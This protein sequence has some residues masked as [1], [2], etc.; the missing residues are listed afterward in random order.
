[1]ELQSL[2]SNQHIIHAANQ[3]AD[4]TTLAMYRLGKAKKTIQAQLFDI[5][6]FA[7]FLEAQGIALA[8]SED[9]KPALFTDLAAWRFLDYGLVVAF[10]ASMLIDGFAIGSINR[11]LST[12]RLYATLAKLPSEQLTHI[13]A[14]HG[15][16]RKDGIHADEQRQAQQ[17]ATRRTPQKPT[18]TCVAHETLAGFLRLPATPSYQQARDTLLLCLMLEM[19][20]R[21]SEVHSLTMEQFDLLMGQITFYREKVSKT[22]THTLPE[23]TAIAAAALAMFVTAGSPFLATTKGGKRSDTPMTLRAIQKRIT[24]LFAKAGVKNVSPH[25][26]RHAWAT[27]ML[28]AGT[29]I[30]SMMSAGGWNSPAMPLRYVEETAIANAGVKQSW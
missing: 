6:R 9:G 5:T 28:H 20:L 13:K 22:Q 16:S 23:Y 24:F 27:D 12:I 11:A 4:M 8:W 30:K 2:D 3:A 21:V 18:P 14:I 25:D 15:F 29:D 19:G 10:K 26:L 17:I 7:Q 1:M